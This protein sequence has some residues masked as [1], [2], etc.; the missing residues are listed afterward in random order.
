VKNVDYDKFGN[1]AKKGAQG[2]FQTIGSVIMFFLKIL[3]KIFGVLFI[4]TGA[5]V[6]I[7][8]FV[9]LFTAGTFDVFYGDLGNYSEFIH[10]AGLPLWLV[11]LLTFFAVGIPFFFLFYLGLKILAGNLKSMPLAG[12]LSLLGLWLISVIGIGVI[13]IREATEYSYTGKANPIQ[14]TLAI[15]ANDTLTLRMKGD[16][17]LPGGLRRSNNFLMEYDDNG[18]RIYMRRNV[19]LIVRST[20]EDAA[21]FKVHK[22][23]SGSNFSK[24]KEE[25]SRINYNYEIA[26]NT[27]Y[28]DGFF[29]TEGGSKFRNQEVQVIL[30]L[31]EGAILFADDNTYSYHSNSR[32]YRDI[33]D[34]GYEEKYLRVQ[35]GDL[36]CEDCSE[37]RD[38]NDAPENDWEERSYEN[39][40]DIPDWEKESVEKPVV[41]EIETIIKKDSI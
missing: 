13:G 18:E 41:E 3:A 24:A 15:T 29:S 1:T 32:R 16:D 22:Q 11:T 2:F 34:N 8:L 10:T 27:L 35:N 17:L 6:V 28:L 33:L 38:S 30:Y 36:I 20:T 25:A 14:E 21:Y 4:I 26:G 7:A 39:E 5:S 40:S 37:K 12:K 31:P 19:R 9:G 23:S